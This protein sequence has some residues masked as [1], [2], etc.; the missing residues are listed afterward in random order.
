MALDIKI[1]F[2]PADC[3]HVKFCAALFFNNAHILLTFFLFVFL[4]LIS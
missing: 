1:F 2:L 3:L 4:I